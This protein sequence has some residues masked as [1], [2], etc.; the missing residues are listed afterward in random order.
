MHQRLL[1]LGIAF[2]VPTVCLTLNPST[3]TL[4]Q[5]VQDKLNEPPP[6]RV[7]ER[8]PVL[9]DNGYFPC[10]DCHDNDSQK[11]NPRVRIL[12]DEHEDWTL[13]HG[14]DRFWCLACHDSENRDKLVDRGGKLIGFDESHLLCGDCHFQ[15]QADFMYGAHGKRL[16]T[17]EGE[18]HIVACA[19]CHDV[20]S[21]RIKPREAWRPPKARTGLSVSSNPRNS[22]AEHE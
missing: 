16:E 4:G 19:Q 12:D 3:P 13:D 8:I 2:I 11:S 5:D 20:H 17:W 15:Q 14:Q 1:W 21:P 9:E 10:S 7:S 22:G 18:R 6:F